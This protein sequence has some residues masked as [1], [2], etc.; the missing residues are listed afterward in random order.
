MIRRRSPR[1][2]PKGPDPE[3]QHERQ[4]EQTEQSAAVQT[5]AQQATQGTPDLSELQSKEF[6]ETAFEPD[7]NR[8]DGVPGVENNRL[9]ERFSAEFGRHVGLGNIDQEE[10]EHRKHANRAQ[11]IL[12]LQEY[13]RPNG[14]GSRCRPGIREAWAGE[15]PLPMRDDD[16]TREI[17]ASFEEKTNLESLSIDA[18]GFDGLTKIHAVTYSQRDRDGNSDSNGLLSR[19]TGGLFGG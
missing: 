11:A 3:E 17:K 14:L 2:N 15:E 16:M 1:R 9:E 18:K 19:V 8:G 13:A 5:A 12:A 6:I 4:L 10:W 7:V